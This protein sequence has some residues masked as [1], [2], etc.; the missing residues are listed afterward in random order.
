[1]NYLA[2]PSTENGV[3]RLEEGRRGWGGRRMNGREEMW[4]TKG[5]AAGRYIRT[6]QANS[7]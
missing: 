2:W 6:N 3:Q 5:Q 7:D 4:D 1:M